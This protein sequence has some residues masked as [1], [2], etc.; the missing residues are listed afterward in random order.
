MLSFILFFSFSG[1]GLDIPLLFTNHVLSSIFPPASVTHLKTSVPFAFI[2]LLENQTKLSVYDPLVKITHIRCKNFYAGNGCCDLS[3]WSVPLPFF[4][5]PVKLC[6][7]SRKFLC[8]VLFF[9]VIDL[10]K[11]CWYLLEVLEHFLDLFLSSDR[12]VQLL[13]VVE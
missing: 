6:F 1:A 7:H 13:L 12:V 3:I 5:S 2:F 4:L 10:F 11:N 8:F 9:W